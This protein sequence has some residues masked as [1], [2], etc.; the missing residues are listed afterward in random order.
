M[1]NFIILR[2][3]VHVL[4]WGEMFMFY[5][6]MSPFYLWKTDSKMMSHNYQES[7]VSLKYSNYA[8]FP[9]GYS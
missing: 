2:K 7:S 5:T 4:I 1:Q 6:L 9:L 3:Q 8:S